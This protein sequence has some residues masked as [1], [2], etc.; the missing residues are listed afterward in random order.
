[1][2]PGKQKRKPWTEAHQ[3]ALSCTILVAL[4]F[5]VIFALG[6]Y[7]PMAPLS[8]KPMKSRQEAQR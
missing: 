6:T 3:T 7:V 1:M 8:D 2:K 5:G 4:I